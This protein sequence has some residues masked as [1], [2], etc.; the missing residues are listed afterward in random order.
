VNLEAAQL[1]IRA[2]K[3]GKD[4]V[5]AIPCSASADIPHGGQHVRQGFGNTRR[6]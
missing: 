6:A 2:A 3:G 4:R 1:I 5:V